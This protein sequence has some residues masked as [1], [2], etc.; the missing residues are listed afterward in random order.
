MTCCIGWWGSCWRGGIDSGVTLASG[1]AHPLVRMAAPAGGPPSA[2]RAWKLPRD[3]AQ[4]SIHAESVPGAAACGGGLAVDRAAA[5]LLASPRCSAPPFGC[6]SRRPRCP[7][8][9]ASPR[10]RWRPAPVMDRV[11][12]V[13]SRQGGGKRKG[14]GGGGGGQVNTV[15]RETRGRLATQTVH[16]STSCKCRW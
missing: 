11:M 2:A 8:W 3:N 4:L 12:S 9:G 7:S 14:R 16:E 15:D 6:P 10:R 13:S 1:S 5:P